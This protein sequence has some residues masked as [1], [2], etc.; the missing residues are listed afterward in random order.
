MEI[1]GDYMPST[2]IDENNEPLMTNKSNHISSN[3][4]SDAISEKIGHKTHAINNLNKAL[5]SYSS[6][7]TCPYCKHQGLT[8]ITKNLNL[9]NLICS[10][11]TFAI[12]WLCWQCV[13]GKDLNCYNVKHFCLKCDA[14]LSDYNAC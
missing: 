10:I 9:I 13:R 14:K 6:Y 4:H 8:K 1:K 12:G 5:K 3:N 11:F 7:V 2:K